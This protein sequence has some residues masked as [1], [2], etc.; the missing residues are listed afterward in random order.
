MLNPGQ[1]FSQFARRLEA[2]GLLD[3]AGIWT[4][5]ARL[6]GDARRV[7]AGEYWIRV[8]DTPSILL[9]RLLAGDVVTYE[10][11]LLE[12]WTVAQ[13]LAELAAH[14]ALEHRLAG[15][16]ETT[17]LGALG[18]GEGNGEGLFFPDT[19]RYVRG[20]SDADIDADR[21]GVEG[22]RA[23]LDA[24][25]A[26]ARAADLAAAQ[27]GIDQAQAQLDAIKA[28]ARTADIAAAQAEIRRAQAQLDLIVAGA[29]PETISALEADL[30]AAKA[31]LRQAD[32]ALADT[33]LKAPFA[34]TVASLNTSAGEQVLPGT[35][36][37]WLADLSQWQVETDDLTELSVVDVEVGAPA[38]IT[39]DAIPDLVLPGTVTRIGA[40]SENKLGDVTY[41]VVIVPDE[42]DDRL[43]WGMTAMVRIEA[44]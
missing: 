28:P 33:V 23:Q 14:E 40:I 43:R 8:G 44:D 11:K 4:L 26:E 31:A 39:F 41:T 12:G 17:V 6:T 25:R 16:D 36:V 22:A 18:L 1:T 42:Q 7:Q 9:D 37:V 5:Q 38:D 3:G 13:A 24:I 2:D 10:V 27:A 19:Y 29:R 21:A 34:G 20:A 32:I 15:A 35:P 30:E